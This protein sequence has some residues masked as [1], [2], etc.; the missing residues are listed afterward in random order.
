MK[1]LFTVETYFPSRNGM[2][3]VTKQL[4]ERF[5]KKG[6]EVIIL[7]GKNSTRNFKELNGVKIEE[8]SIYGNMVFGYKEEQGEIERY[9]QRILLQD[10][11]VLINFAGQIWTT[12]LIIANINQIPKKKIFVPTGFS[13]LNN[14]LFTEYFDKMKKWLKQ[15]DVNVF[16]S[17]TYQDKIFADKAGITNSVIIPNGADE[18]EFT[19]ID[20]GSI[21]KEMGISEDS[22][23]CLLVGGHTNL[24]GHAEAIEI[25]NKAKIKNAVLWIIGSEDVSPVKSKSLLEPI[26]KALR[27]YRIFCSGKCKLKANIFN[28]NPLRLIDKKKII[29]KFV[30]RKE[31]IQAFFSSNLFLF[32]SNLECSPLVIFEANAAGLP[33]LSSDVGNIK[34]IADWTKGGEII[35]TVKNDK[36]IGVIDIKDGVKKLEKLYNNPEL[37]KKYSENGR[38]YCF[39]RFTWDKIADQ[40]LKVVSWKL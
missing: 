39:E 11:D 19:K 2:A 30:E 18:E 4:A 33:F 12:D 21:R 26:K 3:Y 20:K 27:P 8:F 40:Y 31:T 1:I 13:E 23:L 38:K 35:N 7:T 29:I 6:N 22:F 17:N 15:Y 5:V 37:L 25:F 36:N 24:K 32:P 16:L 28:I 10:Y 14:P 34:E 9:K